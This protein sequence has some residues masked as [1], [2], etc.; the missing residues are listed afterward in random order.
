[1]KSGDLNKRIVI[2]EKTVG[3]P[4]VDAFGQPSVVW[5]DLHTVWAAV[6]PLTGRE[7]WAQQQFQ[8]E[9]TTKFRIRYLTDITTEMRIR[10]AG[11][12]YM[13]KSVIDPKEDHIE[14]QFMTEEGVRD[15]D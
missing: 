12:T 10:Y 8:S 2:Q 15:G 5:Q 9:L 1:M 7:F 11:K 3:S 14:L 13:I 6:E 4:A